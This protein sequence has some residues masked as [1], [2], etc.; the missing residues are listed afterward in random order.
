MTGTRRYTGD[1][2]LLHL[3]QRIQSSDGVLILTGAGISRAS[4]LRTYRG[5]DGLYADSE[6]EALHHAHGLPESLPELWGF[7]G[8]RRATISQAPPNAAHL[9]VSAFQRARDIEGRPVT[10]ATQ[11]I[12]DLHERAGSTQVAHLHGSLFATRCYDDA[13]SYRKNP[14]PTPYAEPPRCPLCGNWLRPDVVLFGEQLDVDAQWTAKRAVRDCTLLL[15]IG[16]SGE[17][18]TAT[19]LLRYAADV[20]AL[21]V[22][23]DPAAEVLP[24]FDVHVPVPAEQ[25]LPS[26]LS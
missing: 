20:G 18:S 2:D 10:L 8:P 11:N 24:A 25:V 12:D 7:W 26:L 15:A 16:T 1:L 17:V 23:V 13:C 19:S 3:G 22:T 21:L 14:D 5:D 4:G 6:I 9:A